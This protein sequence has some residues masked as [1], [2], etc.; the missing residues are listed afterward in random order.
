MILQVSGAGMNDG[1]QILPALLACLAVLM[2]LM[3]ITYAGAADTLSTKTAAQPP[4]PKAGPLAQPRSPQQVGLPVDQTQAVIPPDNP[5]TPEKIALGQKLFFDGRLSADGTVACASCHNP[6]RAFTD[7]KP[8]SIGVHGRL[9]QRN[10]PTI[11]NA[12]YNKTQFWDG[13]AQ[14]L[15]DQAA[16]PIVNSIEMGQPNLKAAVARI[17]AVSEYERAFAKYLVARPAARISCAR[18]RPTNVAWFHSILPL[19]TSSPVTRTLLMVRPCAAGISSTPV[20][21]AINAM[22]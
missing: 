10:A 2:I 16:L 1:K 3:I 21:G 4:I 8:S 13:R 7:G 17:A 5:Q 11:L 20:P 9:G 22:R 18:L 6:E 14:T 15:E 19:I 12:L